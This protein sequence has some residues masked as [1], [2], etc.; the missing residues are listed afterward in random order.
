[1]SKVEKYDAFIVRV[2][3]GQISVGNP[4]GSQQKFDK[5]MGNVVKDGKLV[6]STPDVIEKMGAKDA[7]CAINKLSSCKVKYVHRR[8]HLFNHFA[9]D[10][11]LGHS[12]DDWSME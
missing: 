4:L 9:P 7:L 2:N 6:W 3:P 1:M 10:Q 11:S 12:L 5:L 8:A